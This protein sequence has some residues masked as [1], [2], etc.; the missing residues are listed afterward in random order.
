MNKISIENFEF[1]YSPDILITDMV[2]TGISYYTKL[3]KRN[4]AIR[5]LSGIDLYTPQ[6]DDY[7]LFR[8]KTIPLS[9]RRQFFQRKLQQLQ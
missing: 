1:N 4:V 5:Q 2:E 8:R 9:K 7:Y 6:G 3:L